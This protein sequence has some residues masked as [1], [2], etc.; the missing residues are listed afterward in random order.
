[1]CSSDLDA[2]DKKDSSEAAEK[3]D[4]KYR[5]YLEK[6]KKILLDK[7]EDREEAAVKVRAAEDK[8]VK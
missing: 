2:K 8:L 6:Q 1:M 5:V 7:K 4:E 3:Y